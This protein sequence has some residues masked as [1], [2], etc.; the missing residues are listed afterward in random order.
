MIVVLEVAELSFNAIWM[1]L[2]VLPVFGIVE[3]K[4]FIGGDGDG[5]DDDDEEA[6]DPP[7]DPPAEDEDAIDIEL[8][9]LAPEPEGPENTL[10]PPRTRR[11]YEVHIRMAYIGGKWA[12][13]E[14]GNKPDFV[15]YPERLEDSDH[16][17]GWILHREL[18]K[19][20]FL[21]KSHGSC[22]WS[23]DFQWWRTYEVHN[24]PDFERRIKH[25]RSQYHMDR[26]LRTDI[27]IGSSQPVPLFRL[28][29]ENINVGLGEKITFRHPEHRR[30]AGT[31]TLVGGEGEG[32][33][34]FQVLGGAMHLTVDDQTTNLTSDSDSVLINYGPTIRFNLRFAKNV[35]SDILIGTGVRDRG[36]HLAIK[37]RRKKL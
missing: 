19:G 8:A 27:T 18:I 7:A 17:I 10:R 12:K 25:L 37:P 16:E 4:L 36:Y 2:F 23:S 30:L 29:F 3:Y 1:M 14:A 21:L 26:Y 9:A 35:R 33:L 22:D 5:E 20:G 34:S 31:V 11:I 15:P 6:G 24:L 13:F 28:E 32:T